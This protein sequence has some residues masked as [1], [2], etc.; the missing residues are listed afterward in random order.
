MT[1]FACTVTGC[2]DYE[3]P[4]GAVATRTRDR[5]SIECSSGAQWQLRC[6]LGR[7]VGRTYN[8]SDAEW[9]QAWTIGRLINSSGNFSTRA[10]LYLLDDLFRCRHHYH[11]VCFPRY[12]CPLVFRRNKRDRLEIL[13]QCTEWSQFAFRNFFGNKSHLYGQKI[14]PSKISSR[15]FVCDSHWAASQQSVLLCQ[16]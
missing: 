12:F 11:H 13:P 14:Q 10:N 6:E 3:A 2:G 4:P 1:V 7:W 9:T 16:V 15:H 8:C 5:V